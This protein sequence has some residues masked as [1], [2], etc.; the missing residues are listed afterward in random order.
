MEKSQKT[1]YSIHQGN[2]KMY[3]DLKPH[4]W[5]PTMKLDV[6]KYVAECVTYASVKN[7][8]HFFWNDR[9][10]LKNSKKLERTH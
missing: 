5:W 7:Q 8:V 2:T 9:K 3:M 6:A 10:I 4:Y 1:M